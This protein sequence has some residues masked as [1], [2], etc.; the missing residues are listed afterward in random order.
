MKQS[1]KTTKSARLSENLLSEFPWLSRSKIKRL[2]SDRYI[3]VNGVRVGTDTET[4]AGDEIEAYLPEFPAVPVIYSDENIVIADKPAHI[5]SELAL[6]KLL[7]PTYGALY[8][9]HRLDTNTTGIIVLA[10]GTKSKIELEK[11]FKTHSIRKKY[12]AAVVGAPPK[13]KGTLRNRLIK[14][15]EKGIVRVTEAPAGEEAIADYEVLR[16]GD[17][18]SVLALYPQTGR[19]HQ[20]R[21][22]L[23]HI[24]C[25]I[26]GDGKYGDFAENKK[27]GIRE[28]QLRAVSITFE[29]IGGILKYLCG[30]EFTVSKNK[31]ENEEEI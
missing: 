5:D 23:A 30:R 9:V 25:P 12:I 15:S 29:R 26:L 20:L 16:K 6:P 3:K 17:G 19:T 2:I 28:Q 27:R 1:F 14:D 7:T 18:I 11:A 31:E 4:K 8:P 22:Q 10:R 24:K 13:D 21:A